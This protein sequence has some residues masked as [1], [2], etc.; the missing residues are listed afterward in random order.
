ML[1]YLDFSWL[2]VMERAGMH[3]MGGEWISLPF[4]L[5]ATELFR[6]MDRLARL[7]L[8]ALMNPRR[9]YWG[10]HA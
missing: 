3:K 6:W 7:A 4:S 10:M 9:H 2:L 5:F 8:L 1:S